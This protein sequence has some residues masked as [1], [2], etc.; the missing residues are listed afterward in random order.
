MKVGETSRVATVTNTGDMRT[1]G[2]AEALLPEP[3]TTRI[4][5]GALAE[6]LLQSSRASRESRRA[7]AQAHAAER[8]AAQAEEIETMRDNATNALVGGIVSG[9][10][11]LASAGAQARAASA[12]SAKV[13]EA[14]NS[15]KPIQ[16]RTAEAAESARKSRDLWSAGSTGFNALGGLAQSVSSANGKS[17]EADAK[18]AAARASTAGDIEQEAKQAMRDQR[19]LDQAVLQAYQALTASETQTWQTILQRA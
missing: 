4:G 5:A 1:V 18:E 17:L 10:F 16:A 8:K 6:L 15:A 14:G 7:V 9:G 2:T 13:D 3:V 11:Q 12:G 19:D